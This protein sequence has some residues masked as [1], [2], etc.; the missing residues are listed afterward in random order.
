MGRYYHLTKEVSEEIAAEIIK[1]LTEVPNL[2]TAEFT[3]SFQYLKVDTT[4]EA[5]AEVMSRAVNICRR[6][7][8]G[9]G[10]SFAHFSGEDVHI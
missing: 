10:L 1:E 7:G 8:S 6:V 5:F 2:R 9:C 4:E 3:D